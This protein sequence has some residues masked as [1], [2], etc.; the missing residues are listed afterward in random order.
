LQ[1]IS[2]V[3]ENCLGLAPNSIIALHISPLS[4]TYVA[5][6]GEDPSENSSAVD[7]ERIHFQ[8]RVWTMVHDKLKIDLDIW[9]R[10]GD[11]GPQASA[12]DPAVDA[13]SE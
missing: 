3:G 7:F 11:L 9:L 8:G 10:F 5:V 4:L 1:C 13:K 2:L 12:K 6:C